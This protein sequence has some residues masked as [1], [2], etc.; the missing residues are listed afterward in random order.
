MAR[1]KQTQKKNRIFKS[2][3]AISPQEFE[4]VILPRIMNTGD[5]RS[6]SMPEREA[7]KTYL[8]GKRKEL[9]KQAQEMGV[10][11][12]KKV[13]HGSYGARPEIMFEHFMRQQQAFEELEFHRQMQNPNSHPRN[14]Y[15][16]TVVKEIMKEDDKWRLLRKLAEIDSRLNYDRAWASETLHEIERYV[17]QESYSYEEIEEIFVNSFTK[18]VE[19]NEK[20]DS[21][22]HGFYDTHGDFTRSQHTSEYSGSFGQWDEDDVLFGQFGKGF[23]G[24]AKAEQRKNAARK[25]N[26]MDDFEAG[27]SPV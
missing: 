3:R 9:K 15:D 1:K 12:D 26:P 4:E 22:M 5:I 23:H 14:D 24:R 21:N 13:T 19:E 11:L 8:A 25:R 18:L 17:Y 7:F 16:Y 10:T 20:W 6:M 2:R 27:W